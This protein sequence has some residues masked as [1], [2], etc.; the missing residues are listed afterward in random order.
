MADVRQFHFIFLSLIIISLFSSC[1]NKISLLFSS[2]L[3]PTLSDAQ[4]RCRRSWKHHSI[5]KVNGTVKNKHRRY[6]EQGTDV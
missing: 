5:S 2:L 4:L 6:H 3:A 1:E